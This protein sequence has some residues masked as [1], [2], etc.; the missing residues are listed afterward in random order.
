MPSV[1][2]AILL[3]ANRSSSAPP[4]I[5][6]A[7][8]RQLPEP[9]SRQ[10]PVMQC[11]S[12]N[13][14]LGVTR[15]QSHGTNGNKVHARGC[16]PGRTEGIGRG[17]NNRQAGRFSIVTLVCRSAAAGCWMVTHHLARRQKRWRTWRTADAARRRRH[18][19]R[20]RSGSRWRGALAP[21]A[22]RCPAATATA[23]RRRRPPRRAGTQVWQRRQRRRGGRT[24]QRQGPARGC[25]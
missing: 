20:R 1:W 6:L 12:A 13:V 24:A 9:P 3:F 14:E 7:S 11:W 23:C 16:A 21:V 10:V 19:C 8:R 18:R 4:R 25:G 2:L 15:V 5:A 17:H 22:Q